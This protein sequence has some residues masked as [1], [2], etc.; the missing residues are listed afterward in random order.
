MKMK[1]P[2]L[3]DLILAEL[4]KNG[5]DVRKGTGLSPYT[6]SVGNRSKKLYLKYPEVKDK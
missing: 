2:K 6:T 4:N 5:V 3:L 1:N